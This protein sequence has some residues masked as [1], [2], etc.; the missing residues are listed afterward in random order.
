[1]SAPQWCNTHREDECQFFEKV[2]FD[3]N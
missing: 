2:R 1:M 3:M